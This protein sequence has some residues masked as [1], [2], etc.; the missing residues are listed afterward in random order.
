VDTN[1]PESMAQLTAAIFAVTLR[2]Q[3]ESPAVYLLLDET[4][5]HQSHDAGT[6]LP[7]DCRQYLETIQMQLHKPAAAVF[8]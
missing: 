8:L 2:L 6:I 5:L 7:A 1:K 3:L 4:P